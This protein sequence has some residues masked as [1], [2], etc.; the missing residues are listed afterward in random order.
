M[1]QDATHTAI[2]DLYLALFGLLA[3]LPHEIKLFKNPS[4]SF[5]NGLFDLGHAHPTRG[6]HLKTPRCDK[7][8]DCFSF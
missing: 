2:L 1:P 6:S 8:C 7:E 4:F 3:L 5:L